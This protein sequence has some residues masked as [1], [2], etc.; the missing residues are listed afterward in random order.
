MIDVRSFSQLG[1]FRNEWLDTRYH[2]SFSG[3]H[4]LQRMGLGP[5]RVWNDDQ[6]AAGR[7]FDPH[8]HRDMEIITYV[9]SG[10]ISHRDSLGNVGRTQAGGHACRDGDRPRRVQRQCRT[11]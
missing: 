7:G 2:F 1:A 5:L 11:C 4:D 10:A 9:R 8:P 3:Y 6:V